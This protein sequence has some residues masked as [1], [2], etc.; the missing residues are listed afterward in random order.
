M[1]MTVANP[2][3]P[4]FVRPCITEDTPAPHVHSGSV[5]RRGLTQFTGNRP[6]PHRRD[7]AKRKAHL[8]RLTL[9]GREGPGGRSFSQ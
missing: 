6:P 7:Q 5:S 8:K 2:S 9:F 1:A 4:F 3:W